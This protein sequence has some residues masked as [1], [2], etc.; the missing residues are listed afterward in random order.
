MEKRIDMPP[1]KLRKDLK[2]VDARVWV[3]FPMQARF[4]RRGPQTGIAD[5][6]PKF[7]KLFDDVNDA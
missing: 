7:V 2:E 3:D 6:K 5:L 4:E 1:V